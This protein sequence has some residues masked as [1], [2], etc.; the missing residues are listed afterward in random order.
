MVAGA[1]S[2]GAT[3][4]GTAPTAAPGLNMSARVRKTIQSIKEIVG[5]HSE[6]DIYAAL[7][8][9]NMDPNETAQKL[10]NQDDHASHLSCSSDPFHEVRRRRDKKKE[11]VSFKS[12]GV[13]RRPPEPVQPAKSQTFPDRGVRRGGF[14]RNAPPGINREFRV[15]RDN[16]I[17][18]NTNRDVKSAS[19]QSSTNVV[20]PS[21]PAISPKENLINQDSLA[22]R[23]SEDHKPSQVVNRPFRSNPRLVQ[24]TDSG[25]HRK[26]LYEDTLE[27]VPNSA[28]FALGLKPRNSQPSSATLASNNSEVGLYSSSSDPVHVPSPDSR[29]SGA[30]GAIKREV[31]VVG[32]RRQLSENSAKHSSFPSSSL[33]SSLSFPDSNRQSP[34]GK[35]TQSGQATGSES[36]LSDVSASRPFSGNQYTSKVHQVSGHQKV[37]QPNMEWK[38]KSSQKMSA[39]TAAP[40]GTAENLV[41]PPSNRVDTKMEADHLQGRLSGLSVSEN[42]HVIIPQHLQVPEADRMWLTFGSFDVEFDPSKSLA[43]RIQG[44]GLAEQSTGES[45]ASVSAPL[46]SIDDGN[47]VEMLHGQLGTSGSVS[48]VSEAASDYLS[49]DQKD[50][51]SPRNL[52]NYVDVGLIQND[53]PSYT[54]VEQQQQQQQQQQDVSGLPSF[55]A[56]DPQTVYDMPFFNPMMEES[57]RGHGLPSPQEVVSP[58]ISNSIPVST[59]AML[60]QQPMA[61]M[62][63]QMHV[64][65]FPIV[66]YRQYLSHVYVPPMAVPGYSNSPAAYP[67]PSNGNSYVLMPGGSSHL[68]PGGLKYGASQYKPLPAGTATGF[69]SY[70]NSPG[71]AMNTQ[72]AVG[73]ASGLEDS[74]R[75]KYKDGNI[76]V[77]NAQ[78]D[79]SELWIQAP[80]EIPGLQS[81]PFYNVAG[82]T[83]HAAYMPNHTG[84]ASFNV[85]AA[86]QPSPM[87]Y[88]LY[89]PSPQPAAIANHPHMVPAMGGNVGVGVAAAA[90][91]AQVGPY[92]QPQ[93]GHMNWNTNF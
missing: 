31:G 72:G 52:E 11:V 18:Q 24:D 56:Y 1:R 76:F 77:P 68:A 82:Q 53:T 35:I 29:A 9:S 74:T 39:A 6:G 16:R 41:S 7:K 69:G 17:N 20:I 73:G 48:P 78:A 90:P 89:H 67:H 60:Q 34:A 40:L 85:A 27:K 4:S 55:V 91:G 37:T 93:L 59:A 43:S 83:P 8:E 86:G 49:H 12:Y 21:V 2:D 32:V 19:V 3:S 50:S 87:Q 61:H 46:T 13:P 65:P 33:P 58:S 92:Q 28:S 23:N 71:Y 38:P 45:S 64:S 70:S 30:V 42:Q 75:M 44:H 63:P 47:E 36:V 54:S 10:L 66:P 14:V 22:G 88:P 81:T 15:V 25:A 51:S 80:R 5:N 26:G 79:A 62:Y 57:A 84:H